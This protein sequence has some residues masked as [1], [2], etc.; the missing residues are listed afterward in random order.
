MTI[1]AYS[2]T[3]KGIL[4]TRMLR[5]DDQKEFI[6]PPPT[7]FS[8][9]TGTEEEPIN[10]MNPLGERVTIGS[11]VR[12]VTPTLNMTFGVHQ[13]ELYEF[14]L[15]RKFGEQLKEGLALREVTVPPSLEAAGVPAN[16]LG[17][18]TVADQT[19]PGE[20][21]AVVKNQFGMSVPLERVS[22]STT[23]GNGQFAQGPDFAMKFGP[24]LVDQV[25]KITMLL[26]DETVLSPTEDP[27]GFYRMK[28][29]FALT[30]N[31]IV[32]L[33]APSVTPQLGGRSIDPMTPEVQLSFFMHSQPGNCQTI[34]MQFTNRYVA[35]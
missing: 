28:A 1:S 3:I 11:I 5:V 17:G 6:V 2:S 26:A 29:L 15:G 13:P 35:C 32:V 24:D 12:A 33:N 19:T 25:V 30:D 4:Q 20:A 7:A 27:V 22:Y 14:V 21:V 18:G 23:P 34:D 10:S 9:D 31:R 16:A 8:I